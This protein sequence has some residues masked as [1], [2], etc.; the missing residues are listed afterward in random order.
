[1]A[2]LKSCPDTKQKAPAESEMWGT[3]GL[4]GEDR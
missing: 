2:R 3:L 4:V 1:V